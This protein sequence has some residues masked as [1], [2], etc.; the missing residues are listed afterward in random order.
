MTSTQIAE[1]NAQ[2]RERV[3]LLESERDAKIRLIR[4][5]CPHDWKPHIVSHTGRI[6]RICTQCGDLECNQNDAAT[7]R[8]R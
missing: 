7:C 1:I 8:K 4:S 6:T 3:R 5:Q 2:H